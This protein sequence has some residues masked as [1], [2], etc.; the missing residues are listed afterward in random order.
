MTIPNF[1][2]LYS[3]IFR[4]KVRQEQVKPAIAE[5]LIFA[6]R[7]DC[8]Q[9]LVSLGTTVDGLS[10]ESSESLFE[11]YGYNTVVHEKRSIWIVRFFKTF[12]NPLAILLLALSLLSLLTGDFAAT[13]IIIIMVVLGV[14]IRFYQENQAYNSAKTLRALVKTTCTV[15]R[16][17]KRIEVGLGHVVPGDIVHL[18]A[19]DIV[20]ADAR[21][22]FSKD[23]FV[24]QSLL[25]GEAIPVEKYSL[26]PEGN[27]LG[28]LELQ[29][30]C[31]MG[32]NI[33]SGSARAVILATG[34]NTYFGSLAKSLVG[35]RAETSFDKGVERFTGLM[36]RFML[37][38]APLVFLINGFSKGNWWEALLFA[39][40]VAVGLTPEMLPAIVA[41][42]LT[43]GA[44]AMAKKKVVVKR[45]AAIQ[46]FG[47]MDVLCTDKTGTLTQNKVVLIKTINSNGETDDRIF[48]AAYLNSFYQTGF[49]NLLDGAVLDYGDA[50]H[51]ALVQ[52]N[53]SKIDELPFDFIRRR[54]SVVIKD[55]VTEQHQ[56]ICKGAV[57]EVLQVC[58][59]IAVG[60]K[61]TEFDQARLDHVHKLH[62]ELSRDGF[63]V[64]AV[65]SR[66]ISESKNNYDKNDEKDLVFL[67]LMTFLDPPKDSAQEAIALL[68]KYGVEV[69]VLTGDND[70]VTGKICREVDLVVKGTLLGS[71]IEI[72]SDETL[73]ERVENTTIF[74]K[75]SPEHKKRVVKAL[76]A[77]EHVVGF[78]GDGINDAPALRVA[79]VG[80]SVDT[81]V[82]IAKESADIILLEMSLLVLEQGVVEGRK[83]FANILK[84][85][86]MGASS[87]FGNMFS[88]L[89]AS[90]FLPFLPMLPLQL[91]T[92]N[93]LY[94][95]SQTAIPTDSVDEEYIE[96]PRKWQIGDIKKFMFCI[97]P[98]SSI[99][100]FITFGVLIYLF[101]GWH[102]PALFH[103]GWFV[104]SLLTQ[105]L[106]VHV[107]R[108]RKMPFLQTRA[109]M[110]LMLTTLT[111]MVVGI[112][113]VTSKIGHM[114][115]FVPLPLLYWP[116]VVLILIFYVV[117]TQVV[118]T[119]Y[120]KKYGYN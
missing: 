39:I 97:G 23:L 59:F 115:G 99:F 112:F 100:D 111:I 38:M 66:F 98:I 22:I 19:G 21:I 119:W 61:T 107:I 67:G 101:G 83:V 84:Y 62:D 108:S 15:V 33:D 92:N 94:D 28:V 41:I 88:V 1:D 37:V 69:K 110:A 68:K 25:T 118:K 81:G 85:I 113:I 10:S 27:K 4:V 31:Y 13:I 103:T 78:L 24:N 76:Q 3:L 46:N 34:S 102:N 65:A 57:E 70:L 109:S 80:I 117:T 49:K 20:P 8:N 75:L 74:A 12:Y 95:F 45:L 106:I 18:T 6:A 64:I 17:G 96:Q 86:K 32:T 5:K 79:D 42:N 7:Q 52:D 82:D 63:R 43:K 114:L 120:I 53:F 56:L 14:V 77:K 72:M 9:L 116:A 30:I 55:P 36:F 89:G 90:I 50:R 51:S 87:N 11:Q 29:N 40:S 44:I 91:L 93:L 60:E 26:L 2:K 73:R 104:E 35:Q 47:A 105:T 54:L 48:Q 58:N 71:E 16:D